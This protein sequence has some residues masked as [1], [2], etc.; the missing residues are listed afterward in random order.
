[1]W[2]SNCRLSEELP[3]A[4]KCFNTFPNPRPMKTQMSNFDVAAFVRESQA[5]V[6]MQV[7]KV[8]QMSY[9]EVWIRFSAKGKKATLVVAE[10]WTT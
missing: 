9:T 6:G 7:E 8:F 10:T 2:K 4:R 3:P 1:M 5:F